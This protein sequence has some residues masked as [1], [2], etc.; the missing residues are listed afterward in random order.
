MK[1]YLPFLLLLA[2][3]CGGDENLVPK[4]RSGNTISKSGGVITP[5]YTCEWPR[6]W[7]MTDSDY[8]YSPTAD[9]RVFSNIHLKTTPIGPPGSTSWS[10]T[11]LTIRVTT[12]TNNP[13]MPGLPI[14]YRTSPTGTWMYA[15]PGT[16]TYFTIAIPSGGSTCPTDANITFTLYT[17]RLYCS[18]PSN[19]G[20]Q[21]A[22]VGATNGHT[23]YNYQTADWNVN[24]NGSTRT[25]AMIFPPN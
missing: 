5:L 1:K 8:E 9:Q 3:G 13:S 25:C 11:T 23:Y 7:F 19:W 2:F 20:I 21:V 14:K 12:A 17:Q 24:I 15:Y 18:T 22:L 6:E 10:A 4:D 16:N